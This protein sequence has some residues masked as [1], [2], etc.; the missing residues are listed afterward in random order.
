[1]SWFSKL[2]TETEDLGNESEIGNAVLCGRHIGANRRAYVSSLILQAG[3][4]PG[5]VNIIPG[6][7]PTAG[8]AISAHMDVDKVA[9]TGSTEVKE[10][11]SL[12]LWDIKSI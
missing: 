9:F 6:Y 3:F 8:A 12:G 2:N 4:P 1:M 10:D 5:V 11:K 7:G